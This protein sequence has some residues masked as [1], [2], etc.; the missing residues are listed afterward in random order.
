MNGP[1]ERAIEII[2]KVADPD[3]VILFGSRARG[4]AKPES[5][6]DLLVLKN[7][8]KRDHKL[9]QEIYLNFRNIGASVD[10]R[11]FQKN[12]PPYSAGC[13]RRTIDYL[14]RPAGGGMCS[15]RPTMRST[16]PAHRAHP[17]IYRLG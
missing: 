12:K 4:D 8:V 13:A 5:D 7:G 10:V 9:A 17:T 14:V 11:L 3:K 15:V 16:N 6:Y 2:V 1:L